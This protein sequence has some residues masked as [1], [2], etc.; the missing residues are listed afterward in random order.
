MSW[1]SHQLLVKHTSMAAL[2]HLMLVSCGMEVN[3][4]EYRLR[5]YQKT[6]MQEI[7]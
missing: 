1:V 7:C 5:K 2:Y 6:F 4:I 3:G